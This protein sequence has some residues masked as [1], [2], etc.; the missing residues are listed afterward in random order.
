VTKDTYLR[1]LR[2]KLADVDQ[3]TTRW[4]DQVLIDT[5]SDV[6]IDLSVR[7][8]RGMA[9]FTITESGF[10]IEP[11]DVQGVLLALATASE[12]LWEQFRY[13]VDTGTLGVSWTSGLERESTT[14]QAKSYMQ[15]IEGIE[16][17]FDQVL[18]IYNAPQT[19]TRP[20]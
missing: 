8:I 6:L 11:T 3:A 1:F 4:T 16:A 10:S 17:E 15:L 13:R 19:G 2:R 14:G 7:G 18:L 12:L 9:D 5:S 20:H